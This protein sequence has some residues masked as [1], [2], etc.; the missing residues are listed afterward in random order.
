MLN[1]I[2]NPYK[3]LNSKTWTH[4]YNKIEFC[5][6]HKLHQSGLG[7]GRIVRISAIYRSFLR[8]V[9]RFYCPERVLL[10]SLSVFR[11]SVRKIFSVV[12]LKFPSLPSYL[13]C[14]HCTTV[15][16][17][18]WR[19]ILQRCNLPQWRGLINKTNKRIAIILCVLWAIILSYG[20]QIDTNKSLYLNFTMMNV[21]E[22]DSV[23]YEITCPP[24]YVV[25]LQ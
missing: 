25:N 13:G 23:I 20:V 12:C 10:Q 2:P 11:K 8:S 9:A 1:D 16:S 4:S 14:F 6:R 5:N 18:R 19:C 7:S 21:I 17:D 3:Y 22:L 15:S 24:N